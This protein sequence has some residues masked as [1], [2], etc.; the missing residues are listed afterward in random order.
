MLNIAQNIMSLFKDSKLSQDLSYD[1]KHKSLNTIM[2]ELFIRPW[3]ISITTE[4]VK[5]TIMERKE[6][7]KYKLCIETA[8][9]TIRKYKITN[10]QRS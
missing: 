3:C 10:Y 2:Y 6:I 1:F 9:E 8:E 7:G 5:E 4:I